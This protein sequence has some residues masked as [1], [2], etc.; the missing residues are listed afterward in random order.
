MVVNDDNV[1]EVLR[2]ESRS[3]ARRGKRLA[4]TADYVERLLVRIARAESH[5]RLC[6]GCGEWR[7]DAVPRSW[8]D[9][10]WCPSCAGDRS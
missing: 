8:S 6:E 4:R 3:A 10:C 5:L 2:V 7:Y 1:V 9:H